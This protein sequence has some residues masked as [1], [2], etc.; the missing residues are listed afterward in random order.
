MQLDLHLIILITVMLVTGAFGGY[1]NYLND[2]DTNENEQ[3]TGKTKVK[4]VLLGIG[5]AFLI[6]LFLKM[7]ESNIISSSDNLN[8]LI[9][10]G[11]CL[12]AAIFS[13]RFISSI[14]DKILEAAK[15]AEKAALE[16]KV[17]SETTHRELLSTKE[18]IEDVK[19]AVDI[20]NSDEITLQAVDGR[21]MDTL[22]ALAD[23]YVER[24]SVPDY[25]Q[26]LSLKAE[27]G[28]KMGEIIIRNRFSKE[29]MI[30]HRLSEGMMLALAYAVQ[31]RP[32]KGD[33]IILNRITP[34]AGQ[35]FT[36][37]CI[38]IGYDTL[39]RN[40]LIA[41][42]QLEEVLKGVKSFRKGADGPL[43]V[44]IEDTENILSLILSL[45]NT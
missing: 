16:S 39:A 24:T 44:K 3:K 38:L 31:L 36:K 10:T 17:K 29:E 21:P 33:W 41:Q 35:L 11:F 22:I 5:A 19:L 37:Y 45:I 8:Y 9:F 14:G 4:Y 34:Q 42:D 18:R 1:L 20:Q 7:I 27:M 6:P 13:R 26:R 28:R 25:N 23:S 30:N 2:F 32:E 15:N 40:G 12:I 43:L